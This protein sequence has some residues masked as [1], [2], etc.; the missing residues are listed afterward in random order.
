MRN[1]SKKPLTTTAKQSHNVLNV[2]NR[3]FILPRNGTNFK[4]MTTTAQQFLMHLQ[5]GSSSIAIFYPVYI[6]I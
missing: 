5:P 6:I 2:Q 1:T 4:I 3:P